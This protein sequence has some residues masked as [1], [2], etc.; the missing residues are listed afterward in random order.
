LRPGLIASLCSTAVLGLSLAH[1]SHRD[2]DERR[3]ASP[4]IEQRDYLPSPAAFRFLSMG[5]HTLLAD[6]L[7]VRTIL[8][9]SDFAHD[10]QPEDSKWL[11]G[12]LRT[13]SELDPTWRTPYFFGG[14]MLIVCDDLIGSN[15]VFGRGYEILPG[16]YYFPFALSSNASIYGN[17]M[18]EAAHWLQI[19]AGI[20]GAPA[21]FRSAV[22][23]ML[24]KAG[25][26]EV[27]LRYIYEQL[28]LQSDPAV[29]DSLNQRLWL[30]LHDG[31]T[32]KIAVLR[33][34]F[35]QKHGHDIQDVEELK[36]PFDDPFGEGWTLAA[37]G[38]IRA[39]EMER[40]FARKQY[41]A[42]RGLLMW[43]AKSM[44]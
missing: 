13:I 3:F 12:M 11:L 14:S 22:A 16:D 40:R 15:E 17:D 33:Q 30:I 36:I 19:A 9:Y 1:V 18:E 41:L 37:D 25:H 24:T 27:S 32:E 39:I 43:K 7:W 38:V 34:E 20:E 8:V 29:V 4:D 35:R 6:I 5:H 10:C 44:Q 42:E 21:W 23:N 2:V 28:E 26:R 31:Y